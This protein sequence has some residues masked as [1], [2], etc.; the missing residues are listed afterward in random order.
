MFHRREGTTR[1]EPC[2]G[3]RNRL[4]VR[5]SPGSPAAHIFRW[6]RSTARVHQAT[7]SA[8]TRALLRAVIRH[9]DSA[10]TGLIGALSGDEGIVGIEPVGS[11]TVALAMVFVSDLRHFLDMP[12]D[13]PAPARRMA[14]H[15]SRIV[16]AGTASPAGEPTESSLRCT[17]RPA[18]RPCAGLI[19]VVRLEV[20][21]AIEWWCPVCGD[22][23]V[24]SGWEG[25]PFDLR[26]SSP[27]TEGPLDELGDQ[28]TSSAGGPRLAGVPRVSGRW[29]IVEME[30]WD[31]DAIDL[32]G[33]AY[34][35]FGSDNKGSFGFIAIEAWMDV[36]RSD[37]DGLAGV[38]F[39][40][41]GHDDGDPTCGRGWASLGPDGTLSGRIFIH[42]GDD[43]SFVAVPEPRTNPAVVQPWPQIA[44]SQ[45]HLPN[46]EAAPWRDD[47]YRRVASPR[48][49]LGALEPSCDVAV[50]GDRDEVNAIECAGL[51]DVVDHA[52][53]EVDARVR[54]LVQGVDQVLGYGELRNL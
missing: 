48:V 1:S 2:G 28:R 26:R 35:E 51:A 53:C 21:P 23:G 42:F 8:P 22:D 4:V 43:S 31:Q 50:P 18:R 25:S 3:G 20:P 9:W 5:T 34:I 49:W 13:A 54:V 37:R 7:P 47:S 11:S 6:E 39:T 17:R 44:V 32:G 16:E 45:S 36:R 10:P 19:E 46:A 24:I 40:W 14:G 33:P 12:D 30:L 41:E 38:D 27:H 52:A 29:R 15:L